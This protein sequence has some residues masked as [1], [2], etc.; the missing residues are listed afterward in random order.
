M[1][2][3]GW[4]EERG[5]GRWRLNVNCGANEDGS[6]KVIRETVKAKDRDAALKKLG[7]FI[8]K[9][10]NGEYIE[11]SKQTFKIFV[12]KWLKTYAEKNL[13]PKTLYRYKQLLDSRI[14]PALGHIKIDKIKPVH[15]IEFYANLTE[16][17]IREDGREGGL[18]ERTILHHHRLISGILQ[19]AVEWQVIA[20]NPASRV[21]P[22]KVHKKHGKFYN[23]EQTKAL[24]AA[25]ETE[26]VKHKALIYLAVFCGLRCGEIM[27]L[28]WQDVDFKNSLLT[29][30]QAGQYI[31]GQGTFTKE[32]K[33]ESS[34]R[35]ISMPLRVLNILSQHKAEQDDTK[36]ELDNLWHGSDRVFTTRDGK[37]AHPE[38]P[39]QWFP[40]FLKRKKLP[41]LPFHGLRHT[42]AT[43]MISQ[44][45]DVRNL[46]SRLGHANTS[47]TLNIY[48]HALKSVDRDIAEKTDAYIEK[49]F[50][51]EEQN[52]ATQEEH[53]FSEEQ[54]PALKLVK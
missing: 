2:S 30:R 46:S 54:K 23:E 3:A 34:Q 51:Q 17:G 45:A 21:S 1:A 50:S 8:K 19:D 35:V 13:A 47:T 28:D 22:P 14:L 41:P 10:E 5:K 33:N 11:R 7:L 49:M 4:V 32:P 15:L 9:V 52:P 29:I 48:S 20:S 6:R 25:V 37:P 42:A 12:E 53:L 31:P 24:M 36:K 38:W 44:G 16:D 40:K 18:S 39:S 27:G 26:K 43:I